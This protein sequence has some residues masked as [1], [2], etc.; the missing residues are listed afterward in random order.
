VA[1]RM[2]FGIEGFVVA[3]G[4]GNVIHKCWCTR[5]REGILSHV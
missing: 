4:I 5:H 1:A 3:V 2:P